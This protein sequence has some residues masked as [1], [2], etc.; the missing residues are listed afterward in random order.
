MSLILALLIFTNPIKVGDLN[1]TIEH[2]DGW[3]DL[4]SIPFRVV[5]ERSL[6]VSSL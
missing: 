6:L 3:D 2:L 1:L 4:Q 5:A